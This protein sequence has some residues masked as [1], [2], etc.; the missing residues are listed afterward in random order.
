MFV[1]TCCE[2]V[3]VPLEAR[4]GQSWPSV[5]YWELHPGHLEEQ[6]FLSAEPLFSF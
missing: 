5:K 6:M 4:R 1:C 2:I 3:Q